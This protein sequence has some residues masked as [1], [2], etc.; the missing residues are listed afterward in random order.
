[1]TWQSLSPPDTPALALWEER[2]DSGWQGQK[3]SSHSTWVKDDLWRAA[4]WE[5]AAVAAWRAGNTDYAE[6]CLQRARAVLSASTS[7][8]GHDAPTASP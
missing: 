3:A 8:E 4:C 2:L 7:Q 1:M 5:A 6:T